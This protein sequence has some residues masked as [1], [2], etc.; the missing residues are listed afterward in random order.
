M[1]TEREEL[2]GGPCVPTGLCP[3]S[4]TE[5]DVLLPPG[6]LRQVA[7][8]NKATPAETGSELVT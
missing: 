3:E 2:N 1:A 8:P 5:M 7:A 6:S 4:V